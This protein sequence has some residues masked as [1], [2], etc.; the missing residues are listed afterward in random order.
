MILPTA[1]MLKT[2]A[3]PHSPARGAK[4]AFSISVAMCGLLLLPLSAIAEEALPNTEEIR[5]NRERLDEVEGARQQSE[6]AAEELSRELERLQ[7]ER[8]DINARL[9]AASANVQKLESEI[10]AAEARLTGLQREQATLQLKLRAQ[11]TVI[12]QI[13]AALQRMGRNPPP[14][15]VVQPDDVLGAVRSAILMG[16]LVPELREQALE[17]AQDLT[18]LRQLGTEITAQRNQLSRQQVILSAEYEDVKTLLDA[19]DRTLASTTEALDAASK[20][21]R[22]LAREASSLQD[23]IATLEQEQTIARARAEAGR[24][25]ERRGNG[26]TFAALSSPS[27][28]AS[29]TPFAQLRGQLPLPAAGQ[30]V[31]GFNEEDGLGGQTKGATMETIAGASITSP[32]EGWIIYAGEFRS[33]GEILILDAG[34]GYH[35]L[36]AGMQSVIADTGQF[37]LQG[38]PIAQMG[39]QSVAIAG[40]G[41]TAAREKPMLY[42]EFRKDGA[43]ID[44]M[45]WWI[46]GNRRVSG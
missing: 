33:Y 25:L 43:S 19:R 37:V 32:A 13:I 29:Q 8:A 34:N 45:P 18:D 3:S 2:D 46:V 24:Q 42:V 20:R 7:R 14:A 23:L 15:M 1:M 17:I 26:N 27:R 28:I 41:F 4:R 16:T 38:E 5:E 39:T 12:A 44:P 36:M 30:W 9:I 6:Q 35:I 11:E 10:F 22:E 40:L 21:A 31:T